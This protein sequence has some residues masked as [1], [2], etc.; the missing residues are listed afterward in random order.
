MA[1]TAHDLAI[2]AAAL[3]GGD[4][5]SADSLDQMTTF[6]QPGLYGL[7]TDVA[8]FAG[9]RGHGHRGGIRGYESSMWYFPDSDVSVVLLS[10]QGN[11]ITDEPMTKLVKA[12]LG[13]G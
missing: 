9:H 4:V 8:L 1:S 3:Y 10:N 12:L 7:G 13:P 2:W 11:W 5:L 6:L